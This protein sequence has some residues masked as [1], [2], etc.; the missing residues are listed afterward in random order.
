MSCMIMGDVIPKTISWN[1]L[2]MMKKKKILDTNQK[3]F[4]STNCS[5][6]SMKLCSQTSIAELLPAIALVIF[7]K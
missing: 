7:L 2:L 5:L 4:Y 6:V 3:P 1:S